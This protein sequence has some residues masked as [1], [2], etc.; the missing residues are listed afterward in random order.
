MNRYLILGLGLCLAYNVALADDTS[1]DTLDTNA[2]GLI[3]SGEAEADP[4]LAEVFGD[5]DVNG[6]G[7]LTLAEYSAIETD[8]DS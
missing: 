2:D 5:L 7:F 3:T 1:L 6:D 4:G 8:G